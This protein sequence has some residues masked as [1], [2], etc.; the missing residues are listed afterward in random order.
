[1]RP[2]WGW[3]AAFTIAL[4]LSHSVY[5][6]LVVASLAILGG[7]RLATKPRH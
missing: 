2:F 1:M 3:L 6:A 4:G 5:L 7:A